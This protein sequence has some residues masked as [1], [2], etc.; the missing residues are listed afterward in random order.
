MADKSSDWD[1]DER[2][3]SCYNLIVTETTGKHLQLFWR[4]AL[5]KFWYKATC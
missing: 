3:A 1:N 5:A 4:I 2:H